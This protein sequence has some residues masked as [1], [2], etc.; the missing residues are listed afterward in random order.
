MTNLEKE[1][2]NRERGIHW[3]SYTYSKPGGHDGRQEYIVLIGPQ[4]QNFDRV[5]HEVGLKLISSNPPRYGEGLEQASLMEAL[6]Q[7]MLTPYDVF[8]LRPTRESV[9]LDNKPPVIGALEAESWRTAI[10]RHTSY[11]ISARDY[12]ERIAKRLEREKANG[13]PAVSTWSYAGICRRS[14]TWASDFVEKYGPERRNVKFDAFMQAQLEAA[15]PTPS[16]AA[17]EQPVV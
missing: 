16:K 3:R 17:E 10:L 14:V 1:K 5:L 6:T 2:R 15:K 9:K 8:M 7:E 4:S 13:H 12:A 11:K